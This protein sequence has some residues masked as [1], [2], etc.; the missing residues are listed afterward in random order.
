MKFFNSCFFI[1]I[2]LTI[3]SEQNEEGESIYDEIKNLRPTSSVI[4]HTLPTSLFINAPIANAPIANAPIANGTR[5]RFPE[6]RIEIQRFVPPI[7][8]PQLTES[9]EVTAFKRKNDQKAEEENPFV[10]K[11]KLT[12]EIEIDDPLDH[13]HCECEV[14]VPDDDF[15]M[16]PR[17]EDSSDP[18]D[19]DA[20]F[21]EPSSLEFDFD[22]SL[23]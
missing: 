8:L 13:I 19:F 3:C 21:G 1:F 12:H 14:F 7:T 10:K 5:F 16:E 2:A 18:F 6:I 4:I 11:R 23:Y 22:N 17:A 9:T 15:S 20:Y